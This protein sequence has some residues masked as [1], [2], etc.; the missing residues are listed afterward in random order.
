[1]RESA[2]ISHAEYQAPRAPQF[3]AGFVWVVGPSANSAEPADSQSAQAQVGEAN[4]ADP[5]LRSDR[6]MTQRRTCLIVAEAPMG[7]V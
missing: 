5:N 6:T 3:I 7:V 1:V 2:P 4:N